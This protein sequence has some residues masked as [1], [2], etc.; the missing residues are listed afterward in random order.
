MP[1]EVEN[2]THVRRSWHASTDL[3][4][5]ILLGEQHLALL[6]P[7]GGV[8]PAVDIRGRTVARAVAAGSPITDDDLAPFPGGS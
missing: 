6:R 8:S 2:A 4:T 3:A 7:E 1:S 5:G